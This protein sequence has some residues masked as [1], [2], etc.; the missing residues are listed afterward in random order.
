[1]YSNASALVLFWCDTLF[2]IMRSAISKEKKLSIAAL[3]QTLHDRLMPQMMQ[4][5]VISY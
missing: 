3:P 4:L 1:M 2:R 5:S